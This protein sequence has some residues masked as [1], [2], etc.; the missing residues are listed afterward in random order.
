MEED[1]EVEGDSKLLWV[2]HKELFVIIKI[3]HPNC[4]L[5]VAKLYK[6]CSDCILINDT[7]KS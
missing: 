6:V 4:Y 7:T 2:L 5:A 3:F 1:E